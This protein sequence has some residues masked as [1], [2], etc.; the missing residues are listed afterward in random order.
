VFGLALPLT[1]LGATLLVTGFAGL[2]L[3][4]GTLAV[5]PPIITAI[6][7]GGLRISGCC[8]HHASACEKR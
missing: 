5:V 6:A 3:R 2:L 4:P 8:D 7:P 1:A